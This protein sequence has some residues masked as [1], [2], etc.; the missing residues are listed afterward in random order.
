[1]WD[2]NQ[3]NILLRLFLKKTTTCLTEKTRP[4]HSI[5]YENLV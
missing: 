1:M 5:L 2:L 4:T 3:Y